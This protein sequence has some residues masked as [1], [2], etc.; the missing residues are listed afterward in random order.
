MI[1]VDS[2]FFIGLADSKDQW[3]QDALKLKEYVEKEEIVVTNLIISEV[4]TE[5]GKRK[6]GKAGN[7]LYEYFKDNCQILFPSEDDF[8]NAE[9]TYLNFDGKLSIPDS[10]SIYYMVKYSITNIVSFD[11]D[12]DKVKGIN[13]IS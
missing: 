5:I 2:S 12:F 11:S 10:V 7:I 6:G 13:R 4:L 1:I 9:L 3:H 8:D